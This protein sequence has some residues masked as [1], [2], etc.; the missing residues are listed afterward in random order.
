[1]P[2]DADDL[3]GAHSQVAVDHRPAPLPARS[4]ADRQPRRRRRRGPRCERRK[5]AADHR[6]RDL[7]GAG[8]RRCESRPTIFAAAHHRDASAVA[9]D[10]GELVGD[11]QDRRAAFGERAN[12]D[13]ERVDLGRRERRRRFV[14]QQHRRARARV[15]AAVRR[16][17]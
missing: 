15:R 9:D 2:G 5:F 1:M 6:A 7:G 16:A 10:F 3:A 4:A 12:G 11:D 17:A 14:E 8:L 13:E